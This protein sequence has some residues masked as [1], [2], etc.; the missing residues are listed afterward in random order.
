MSARLDFQVARR[1]KS[2]HSNA[3]ELT[4]EAI[5][6]AGRRRAVPAMP[7][8]TTTNSYDRTCTSSSCTWFG[9]EEAS[10]LHRQIKQSHTQ[11][12]R[13]TNRKKGNKRSVTYHARPR[14][15]SATAPLCTGQ[16]RPS[17][18]GAGAGSSAGAKPNRIAGG[19]TTSGRR[20]NRRAKAHQCRRGRGLA[21]VHGR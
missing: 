9:T 11:P 21:D 6:S 4:Q 1:R 5:K 19:A 8:Q 17:A 10:T 20:P 15:A 13:V 7:N 16:G 2:A 3:Q 12:G 18:K 14:R